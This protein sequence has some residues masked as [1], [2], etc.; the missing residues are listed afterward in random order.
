MALNEIL[1]THADAT[2]PVEYAR[3]IFDGVAQESIALKLMTRLPD[4]TAKQY[5]IP[6][7]DS[8]P[9]A[10]FQTASETRDADTNHKKTS[11]MEWVGKYVTAEEIAVIIPIS[12]NVL[13]DSA[14]DLIGAITPK[15]VEAFGRVFDSAV[16]FGTG[17]SKPA[18]Y[19]DGIVVDATA[20][21]KVYVAGASDSVYKQIDETMAKVEESGYDVNG[22]VGG[23]NLKHLMRQLVDANGQPL[24]AYTDVASLPRHILKNGGWTGTNSTAKFVVGDFSQAVYSIRQDLTVKLL[25]Q[26]TIKDPTTGDEINL[27]QQDMVALRFTMRIGWQLPNPVNAVDGT[28]SRYPFAICHD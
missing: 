9:I 16:F 7:A 12:E 26:A 17:A 3:E 5:R 4:M 24:L 11:K 15:V 21:S 28:S 6:V 19:P 25:D 18:S 1:R 13:A 10:Y 2:I 22:I 27:A 8:L 23:T 14:Y 20:K